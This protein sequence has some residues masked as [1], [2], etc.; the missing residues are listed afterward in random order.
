MSTDFIALFDIAP[1]VVTPEWLLAKLAAN[2]VFAV[3]L[4]ER[5]RDRW[6]P[7]AWATETAPVTG[8]PILWGPGGFAL[9]FASGTLDLYHMM[10]FHTFAGD[11][12]SRDALRLAC[13]EIAELVGSSRALYT[14]ELMPH[15]GEGLD[16]IERWLR[17][18]I[19]PPALTF[20]E[21]QEADYFGPRAWYI[22]SFADL[23]GSSA[24]TRPPSIG[25]C[26]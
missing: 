17:A 19:G 6:K 3:G 16:E 7:K 11:P 25:V 26:Y 12:A 24:G 13:L 20:E 1:G 9:R 23:R 15:E 21:L 5:Y 18:Q 22:D 4:V 2:P 8:S 10:P 14:H